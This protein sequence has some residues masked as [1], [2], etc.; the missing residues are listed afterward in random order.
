MTVH[1]T[2]CDTGQ[3]I[4]FAELQD[5]YGDLVYTDNLGNF[6]VIAGNE[7][8]LIGTA[9]VIAAA[10]YGASFGNIITSYDVNNFCLHPLQP[11]G[12]ETSNGGLY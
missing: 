12:T 8:S 11:T 10:G 9:I 7:E 3:P 2:N 6:Q 4:A 5:I 1:V